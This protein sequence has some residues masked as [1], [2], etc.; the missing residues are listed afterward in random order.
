MWSILRFLHPVNLNSTRINDLEQYEGDLNFNEIDFPVKV[1]D[2]TK[3][4][5]QNPSLSKI[6]V[7]SVYAQNKIYPVRKDRQNKIYFCLRKMESLTILLSTT[8]FSIKQTIIILTLISLWILRHSFLCGAFSL[9]CSTGIIFGFP[10]ITY[11][12]CLIPK[13]YSLI[14]R[15]RAFLR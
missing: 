8:C 1:L 3:F 13:W 9:K 14:A 11:F 10:S 12:S 15:S 2:V 7:F 4:E 6:N 5:K